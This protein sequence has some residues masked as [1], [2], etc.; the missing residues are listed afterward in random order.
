MTSILTFPYC[1]TYGPPLY[2][3]K[4]SQ[5]SLSHSISI[6]LPPNYPMYF[7]FLRSLFVITHPSKHPHFCYPHVLDILF[8]NCQHLYPL[9]MVGL[10]P[11]RGICLSLHILEVFRHFNQSPFILSHLVFHFPLLCLDNT[12]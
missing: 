9:C 11:V 3:N 2:M 10:I 8:H 6:V 1:C 12:R 5:M 7:F 4:P